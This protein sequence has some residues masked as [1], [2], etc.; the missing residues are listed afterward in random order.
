MCE[1]AKKQGNASYHIIARPETL[2][3]KREWLTASENVRLPETAPSDPV[4]A[5][6]LHVGGL[7]KELVHLV[8]DV[9]FVTM[10]EIGTGQF[11]LDAGKNL[12]GASIL[13]LPGLGS[14]FL[15]IE[16]AAF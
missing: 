16:N 11:L 10:L 8:T 12:E 2:G 7:G 5:D 14:T 6:V 4:L 13:C 1:R 15:D 9:Q 3:K